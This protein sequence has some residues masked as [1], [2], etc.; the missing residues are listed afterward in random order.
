MSMPGMRPAVDAANA[1]GLAATASP[2]WANV[3]AG[4]PI[5]AGMSAV[6]PPVGGIPSWARGGAA[7][8]PGL[9]RLQA[10]GQGPYSALAGLPGRLPPPVQPFLG[11]ASRLNNILF[12]INR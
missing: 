7:L 6:P 1:A 2:S 5:Q 11:N 4:G 8:P 9:A 3:L 10:A 12:P